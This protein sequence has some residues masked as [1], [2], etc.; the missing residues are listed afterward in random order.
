M[1]FR[2]CEFCSYHLNIPTHNIRLTDSKIYLKI[3]IEFS[4]LSPYQAQ[5]CGADSPMDWIEY[6]STFR[7]TFGTVYPWPLHCCQKKNN[8]EIVDLEA[9]KVGQASVMFTK[10][11]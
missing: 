4:A 8:Y 6:N 1:L 5:C 7:E 10:V 3:T 2:S 9:C 11:C